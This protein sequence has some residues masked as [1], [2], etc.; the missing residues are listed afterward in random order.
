MQVTKSSGDIR[1]LRFS[2]LAIA[3]V[4]LLAIGAYLNTLSHAFVWDDK[5]LIAQNTAIQHLRNAPVAFISDFSPPNDPSRKSG[6][7]RPITTLSYMIDVALWGNNPRG[8]HGTNVLLHALCSVL[9]YVFAA[10]LRIHP[11]TALLAAL[12]FALH[13]V[14]T[15]SVAWISGRTDL[16]CTLFLLLSLLTFPKSREDP[17]GKRR[18][19]F[20][21]GSLLTFLL[22]L[23][24]K[25]TAIVLPL[26][27][28]LYEEVSMCSAR[29]AA[30]SFVRRHIGYWITAVFY[31]VLRVFA[32]HRLGPTTGQHAKGLPIRLLTA[33]KIVGCYLKQ[34]IWPLHLNA[35]IDIVPVRSP[36]DMSFL[37]SVGTIIALLLIALRLRKTHRPLFFGILW[38]FLALLPVSNLIPLQDEV[39]DRFLYTPSI[40]FL[41]ALSV[42]LF[43]LYEHIGKPSF[44]I[45]ITTVFSLILFGYGWSTIHRNRD[46]KNDLTLFSANVRDAPNASRAH[47]N[48]ATLFLVRGEYD[49]AIE[50]LRTAV[51]LRPTYVQAHY[52]LACAYARKGETDPAIQAL[53]Q[54]I[55]YGLRDARFIQNDPDL[56]ALH[57]DPRFIA[58]IQRLQTA[59]P[60]P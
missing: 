36:L 37:L 53:T 26:L 43:L 54:A 30:P 32:L 38:F 8:F 51:Q 57:S 27:L 56:Q 9:V 34:M 5:F 39:A 50:E 17:P 24:A 46:W 44:R 45:A 10:S 22:A 1:T 18:V 2:N 14:H 19:L 31:I 12:L 25:E 20:Q 3:L 33:P 4:A 60:S 41:V 11:S 40:G 6:Y 28:P 29:N 52:N 47:Y 16:L 59:G 13:P 48:L 55:R 49:R 42:V 15:E 21:A 35:E 23:W 58:L 7:Y